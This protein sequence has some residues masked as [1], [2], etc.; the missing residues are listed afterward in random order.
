[1]SQNR[2][3]GVSLSLTQEIET[4][5]ADIDSAHRRAA[6]SEPG[7][8]TE[9]ISYETLCASLEATAGAAVAA[10][11]NAL[12][13]APDPATATAALFSRVNRWSWSR[14]NCR[15][16]RAGSSGPAPGSGRQ[17]P[18]RL[19]RSAMTSAA[20]RSS[21][22]ASESNSRPRSRSRARTVLRR[23]LRAA[24]I[25]VCSRK[26]CVATSTGEGYKPVSVPVVYRDGSKAEADFPFRCLDLTDQLQAPSELDLELRLTL[27]VDPPHRDGPC[28]RRC[29]A[30]QRRG[31]EAS[32]GRPDRRL[33]LP[34]ECQ[35]ARGADR[36][37]TR[38]VR[39]HIFQTGLETAVVGFFRAVVA[40]L[41]EHPGSL[42]VVPR[43]YAANRDKS[44]TVEDE[45]A[46]FE[47]GQAWATR[48]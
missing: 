39:L 42:E 30:A 37:G 31:V 2:T 23:C 41:L 4:L 33:R 38:K 8:R 24:S 45:F 5:L 27:A 6:R 3:I 44:A 35:A 29:L 17:N 20:G 46:G 47:A 25:T 14:C 40:F 48:G 13:S 34:R 15:W 10:D 19:L 36:W 7:E 43:F 12:T 1:M 9:I 26:S 28:G 22:L 18:R 32:P 11:A 16:S 21:R